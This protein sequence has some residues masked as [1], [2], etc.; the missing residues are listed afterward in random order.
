LL[1]PEV[2]QVEERV[3]GV[4][5]TEA[6]VTQDLGKTYPGNVEAVGGVSLSVAAGEIFAF[7]GPNG[8]GKTTM[9]SMLTTLLRPSRGS[10]S[11]DGVDVVTEPERVRRRIG[12]VFQRSTADEVL[13]GRENL[14]VAAGLNGL[15]PRSST[16][17]IRALLEQ[18]D[19]TDAADRRVSTY[20]GGMRRR[21][22][23][24][25]GIV[26]DP[27]ILFLD[28]PTLGLDP[29]GR[30]GFWEYIR[31]LRAHRGMTI[32]LT[33]HYL[34]EADQLSD[35]IAIL[36]HGR[37]LTTG[38]A[39]ALKDSL[40]SDVVI[41]RPASAAPGLRGLLERIPGVLGVES[42]AVDGEYR[43]KV[44]RSESFVPVVVRA[45]DA[46]GIELVAVSTRKPSLD[47]VFL[48][49]TG[50]EYREESEGAGPT[51]SAARSTAGPR[52]R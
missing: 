15:S 11:V 2:V 46:A 21:L 20:S 29:Q 1:A 49:V 51:I 35:R 18:L 43:V 48:S 30:A 17:R 41:V 31:D 9:V 10:A 26:H 6:I 40:G 22:E 5:V 16:P 42:T 28:E 32:F 47:E 34:D 8:A 50:R 19:L 27:A 39:R 13:T 52:G 4:R 3:G 45:C 33:T 12:L 24:A 23:I 14:E 7:L 36:D 25:A 44:P 37:V 38:T